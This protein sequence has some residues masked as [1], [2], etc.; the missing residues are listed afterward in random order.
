MKKLKAGFIG[1]LPADK[2]FDQVEEIL[3]N[4]AE[5]GYRGIELGDLLLQ[6]PA[7]CEN[8]KKM[9]EWG[10]EPLCV[11]LPSVTDTGVVQKVIRDAG[12]IG[13]KRAASFGGCIAEYRFGMRPA[14]PDYDELML[15][16]EKL[17][18]I[19]KELLQ[20]GIITSFH[21]HDMEFLTFYRGESAF[22]H[23][24]KNSEYLK[25]ELDCGW[26][27][28]AH[29]DPVLLMEELGDKLCAVHIKD[30]GYGNVAWKGTGNEK[31]DSARRAMPHFTTPGT[32]TLPLGACLG[33]AAQMDIDYAIIEQDFMNYNN[34]QD[35]LRGAYLNMKETGYVD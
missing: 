15:E 10:M 28:Y 25:F 13:V 14:E 29:R 35:T 3:K 34:D 1:F 11:M 17:N 19:A 30:W 26:A 33:K 21:N 6:S 8:L 23:M 7:P 9:K 4:Y 5:I 24:V 27:L 18:I 16:V 31:E 32:G 12:K 20:E 2:D 22:E